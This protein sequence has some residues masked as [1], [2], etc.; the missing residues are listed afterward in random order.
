MERSTTIRSEIAIDG[1]LA[2][3]IASPRNIAWRCVECRYRYRDHYFYFYFKYFIIFYK[4]LKTA[5]R[6]ESRLHLSIYYRSMIYRVMLS[7]MEDVPLRF[8]G[9]DVVYFQPLSLD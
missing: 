8:M 4:I 6:V 2:I 5:H 3:E 7:P 1:K 9:Q